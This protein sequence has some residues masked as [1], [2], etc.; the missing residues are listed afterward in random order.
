MWGKIITHRQPL[1]PGK[2]LASLGILRND[3]RYSWLSQQATII[4]HNQLIAAATELNVDLQ[5]EFSMAISTIEEYIQF[6]EYE[7]VMRSCLSN[8]GHIGTFL[9]NGVWQAQFINYNITGG[10]KEL[11]DIHKEVQG[12]KYIGG[13]PGIMGWKKFYQS[14]VDT[15]NPEYAKV[16]SA[17]LSVMIAKNCAPFLETVND[18]NQQYGI[19]PCNGP[20]SVLTTFESKYSKKMKES[21]QICFSI[22]ESLVTRTSIAYGMGIYNIET[23]VIDGKLVTGYEWISRQQNRLF[24][25]PG[26]LGFDSTGRPTAK[27]FFLDNAGNVIRKFEGWLP[28][29]APMRI[30]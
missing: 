16:I 13:M 24:V 18:G 28:K 14:W 11:V 8:P 3:P 21:Y 7:K 29:F 17:K 10:I 19:S 1:E 22:I 9:A 15:R 2:I 25:I 4:I 5:D 6:G 26:S 20:Y 12:S 30:P 23:V 27:G